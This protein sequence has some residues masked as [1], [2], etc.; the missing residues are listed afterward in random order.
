M[1]GLVRVARSRFQFSRSES[2]RSAAILKYLLLLQSFSRAR[3]TAY[4]TSLFVFTN[5]WLH[6]DASFVEG[7]RMICGRRK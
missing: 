3:L 6:D 1:Y 4:E 5:V 2:Q 7:P